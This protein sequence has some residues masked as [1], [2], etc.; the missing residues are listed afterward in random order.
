MPAGLCAHLVLRACRSS[1]DVLSYRCASS[2]LTGHHNFCKDWHKIMAMK[3]FIYE[4]W[5]I[6]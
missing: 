3:V 1:S 4:Y 5:W 2:N 6:P